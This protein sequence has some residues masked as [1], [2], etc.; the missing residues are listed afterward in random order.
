LLL[1]IVF[2][3]CR[4]LLKKSSCYVWRCLSRGGAKNEDISDRLAKVVYFFQKRAIAVVSRFAYR[5][6]HWRFRECPMA[7]PIYAEQSAYEFNASRRNCPTQRTV[8]RISISRSSTPL[9]MR[10]TDRHEEIRSRTGSSSIKG[11]EAAVMRA[12]T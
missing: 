9:T 3:K 1:R 2:A 7:A 10:M 11:A 5:A 8:A 6:T 4:F 12:E